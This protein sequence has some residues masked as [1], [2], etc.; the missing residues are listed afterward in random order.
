ML[1]SETVSPSSLSRW[2][3]AQLLVL[4]CVGIQNILCYV[5]VQNMAS[6]L[7]SLFFLSGSMRTLVGILERSAQITK[8]V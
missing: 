2:K 1:R 6:Q 7:L 4:A 5:L 3:R 8:P